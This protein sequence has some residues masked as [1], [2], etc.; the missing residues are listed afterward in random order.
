MPIIPSLSTFAAEQ[1]KYLDEQG[2]LQC[3]YFPDKNDPNYASYI[4]RFPGKH[5]TAD[6]LANLVYDKYVMSTPYHREMEKVSAQYMSNCRQTLMNWVRKPY[7][8]LLKVVEQFKNVAR[9]DGRYTINNLAAERAIRPLTVERNNSM[10]FCLHKGAET[11]VLYHTIIATCKK[12]GYKVLDYLKEFF[13]QII[14][15]RCDYENLIPATIGIK[16][17]NKR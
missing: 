4:D 7:S 5:A 13:K 8:Y 15:G 12:Q 9:K 1:K 11:S 3:G 2:K 14:L 16:T 10:F 6:F 17:N